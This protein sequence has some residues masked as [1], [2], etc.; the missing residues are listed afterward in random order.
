LLARLLSD[1]S[2]FATPQEF[3][4]AVQKNI[5][6]RLGLERYSLWFK[7]TE[8]ITKD[9]SRLV[10]GVPNAI[11]QQFL[12]ERYTG[13]VADAVEELLG[14]RMAV[15]FDIAPRLFRQMRAQVEADCRDDYVESAAVTADRPTIGRPL[16]GPEWSFDDLIVT[17]SNRL[18]FAA[19]MDLAGQENPRV[20][21]LYICGDYGTGKTALLQAI[22]GLA[23]GPETRL[24]PVLMRA[25]Q[26]CN[27]YY[28][29][30]QNKTTRFFRNRYR[31]C[32]MLMLDDIQFVEG[33]AGGQREL[34]H[35]IK[36]ILGA[37]G[38]VVLSGK[39]HADELREVD[40]AFRALLS[41]AF[42]G[43]LLRPAEE[44]REE[45]AS[46]LAHRQG[47]DATR[48]LHRYVGKNHGESFA[49]IKS[50]VSCL[51]LYARVSGSGKLDVH[52]AMRAFAAV[53]PARSQPIDLQMVADTVVETYGVCA[54]NLTGRGRTRALVQARHVA[55]YLARELTG[56]S[57]TEIG[58]FFGGLSHSTVKHGVD[59][60][61]RQCAEDPQFADLVSRL[62]RRLSS[63]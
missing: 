42:P 48:D 23:S 53:K 54:Q 61:E 32:H 57:L 1:Q 56:S 44:E 43:V 17:P 49:T 29:A 21:F 62:K 11:I 58:R 63:P 12:S 14:E 50:A 38:R 8:L 59:K 6:D 60:V 39:P 24:E 51:A 46:E 34:L 45:I 15:S 20:Q 4:H 18:P 27:E 41:R 10:V 22:Y 52:E 28:L 2:R 19:A 40:A 37:G 5:R 33:K 35:T 9:E 55:M 13:A 7:Q 36:D 25:E 3:W 31:H 47:L 30:I 26:W 16:P